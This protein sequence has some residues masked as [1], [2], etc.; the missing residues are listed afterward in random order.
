MKIYK[1]LTLSQ[2]FGAMAKHRLKSIA[3]FVG[4]MLVI[5]CLFLLWPRY[6]GSEGRLFV[7]GETIVDPNEDKALSGTQRETQSV[8]DLLESRVIVESVVD[9]IGPQQILENSFD[10]WVNSSLLSLGTWWN[11]DSKGMGTEEYKTLTD[12]ER[13]ASKLEHLL[14]NL[15]LK[16][17]A[18]EDAMLS[19]WGQI[20]HFYG[21][22]C[23]GI[24]I[25]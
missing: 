17:Q 2:V 18:S 24:S 23:S 3:T 13:A 22:Y 10:E 19:K 21:N 14:F 8:I 6:Y 12:R 25:R 20:L 11:Q 7:H 1:R 9:E 5:A 16:G 15:L 4:V